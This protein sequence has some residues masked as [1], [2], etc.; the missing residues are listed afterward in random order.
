MICGNKHLGKCSSIT[1]HVVALLKNKAEIRGPYARVSNGNVNS[2]RL[3]E[4]PTTL[5]HDMCRGKHIM[6]K[7]YDK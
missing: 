4:I 2:F 5:T 1:K 3:S 6:Q 7:C